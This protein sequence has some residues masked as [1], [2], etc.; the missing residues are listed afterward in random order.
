MSMNREEQERQRVAAL[1]RQ[2]VRD[3]APRANKALRGQPGQKKQRP[4]LIELFDLL[5]ARWKGAL[6]GLAVA[7]VPSFVISGATSGDQRLLSV[8]PLLGLIA[9]GF[10]GGTLLQNRL[11]DRPR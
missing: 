5:P 10:V 1:R 2:Q 9:V 8:I 4:L 6:I 7:L 3:R 11:E